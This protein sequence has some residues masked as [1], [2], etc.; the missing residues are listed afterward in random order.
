VARRKKSWVVRRKDS[1][2]LGEF[3]A[4]FVE[5]KNACGVESIGFYR[6]I[7]HREEEKNPAVRKRGED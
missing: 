2:E 1:L 4:A 7:G 3:G 6:R 5:E